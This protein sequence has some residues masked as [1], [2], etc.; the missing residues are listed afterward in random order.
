[1]GNTIPPVAFSEASPD[2]GFGQITDI[3]IAEKGYPLTSF[4]VDYLNSRISAQSDVAGA[5]RSLTVIAD[6]PAPESSDIEISHFRKIRTP[7]VHTIN[8]R[9][10][11]TND[12]NYSFVQKLEQ[13]G[14]VEVL[15]WYRTNSGKLYGGLNGIEASINFDEIIPE[16]GDELN[17]FHGTFTWK[18]NHP[19]RIDD[20]LVA[21]D[22]YVD[23]IV[24]TASIVPFD[25]ATGVDANAVLSIEFSEAV[26]KIGGV[27]L[28]DSNVADVLTFVDS[29][30]V[31]VAF[32]ATILYNKKKIVIT[33]D[34]ALAA[35]DYTLTVDGVED[36]AGNVSVLTSSTFTV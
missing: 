21:D 29:L 34:A 17:T 24:P 20:P 19:D 15:I 6:K 36:Y 31:P 27:M 23:S 18:G 13:D 26:R 22:G 14:I 35:D 25:G 7:K 30:S 16:S 28:E 10:D 3:L 8:A 1:M 32:S 11:E 33:P 12:Q 4:E 5:I 2:I 9:I